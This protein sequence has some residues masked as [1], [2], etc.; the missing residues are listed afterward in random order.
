MP[1]EPLSEALARSPAEL[2]GRAIAGS[3][4][5]LSHVL[6][7]V[8]IA[9][10]ANVVIARSLGPDP[11][12]ILASLTVTLGLLASVTNA[13]VSA[14]VVRFGAAAWARG[15]LAQVD[16][17]LAKSLGYHLLVQMPLMLV[18]LWAVTRGQTSWVF[19]VMAISVA[20]PTALGSAVLAVTLE[21]RSAQGARVAMVAN[22]ISQVV[23][24]AIAVGTH[25]GVAVWVARALIGA[26]LQPITFLALVPGRRAAAL[27]ATWPVRWPRGFWAYTL[28]AA[29]SGLLGLFV[30]SRSEVL[31]LG[32]LNEST[33]AGIYA[34][35]FGLAA[36]ITAPVDAIANALQAAA[37]GLVATRQDA[38][39]VGMLRSLRLTSALASTMAIVSIPLGSAAIPLLYGDD[40]GS[41]ALPFAVIGMISCLQSAVMP[42]SAFLLANGD[43]RTQLRSLVLAASVDLAL[44]FALIPRLG[45]WGAVAA[46]CSAQLVSLAVIAKRQAQLA[47]VSPPEVFKSLKGMGLALVTILPAV[48][49]MQVAESLSIL[50][51]PLVW[52]ALV[53]LALLGLRRRWLGALPSD[54]AVALSGLHPSIRKPLARLL[55]VDA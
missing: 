32:W 15:N 10:L 48:V 47:L 46:N 36:Q 7:S 35:A 26:L 31:V 16:E 34:L 8:P 24:C 54:L 38:Q 27:R 20:V 9:F 29:A 50:L 5:T 53:L 28:P 6:V 21:N 3:W 22:A 30:F 40:F 19:P 55:A 11:Y 17:I 49:V 45:L 43:S 13:G 25:S 33:A 41:A 12:G 52:V 2:Q 23:V 44:A 14:G 18:G 39:R 4:W 1:D 42:F 37:T 51:V